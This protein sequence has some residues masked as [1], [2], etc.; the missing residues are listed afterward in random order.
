MSM[1]LLPQ[2]DVTIGNPPFSLAQEFINAALS[3]SREVTFLL[4]LNF[5]GGD[6]RSSWI[7]EWY[8]SVFVLPNRVSG[9]GDGK[10]DSTEY[11]W[12][13][14]TNQG[15]RPPWGEYRILNT[16]PVEERRRDYR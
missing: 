3:I 15:W 1:G 10:T 5:L 4:R 16:T 8:P 9:T 12:M 7:R 2:F 6:A 13:R 11:A 14:F